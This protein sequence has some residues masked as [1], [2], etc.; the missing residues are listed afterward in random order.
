MRYDHLGWLVFDLSFYPNFKLE[1]LIMAENAPI[2]PTNRTAII[3]LASALLTLFSFC[4][5]IVPIPF[6]GF[7]CFPAASVLG[8]AAFAT[9]L[10]S[11]NQIRSNG[12]NG[13]TYALLGTSIGGLVS[14]ASLCAMTVGVLWLPVIANFIHQIS[15]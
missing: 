8:L 14:L 5:A 10:T 11:L 9:G 6:T 12:E 3:S 2:V 13:R 4:I 1:L 15:K 7:L